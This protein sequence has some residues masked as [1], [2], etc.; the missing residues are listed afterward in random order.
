MGNLC[1]F[2]FVVKVPELA[3]LEL[4]VKDHSSS[5]SDRDIASFCS[6]LTIVHQGHNFKNHFWENF[7]WRIY[8]PPF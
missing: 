6:P 8:F 3:F 7:G 5:G 2:D 4:K 1:R